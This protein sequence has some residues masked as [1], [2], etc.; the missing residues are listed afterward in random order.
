MTSSE[1]LSAAFSTWR[2]VRFAALGN[3]EAG[4][5]GRLSAPA[6]AAVEPSPSEVPPQP[7]RSAPV[8]SRQKS[9]ETVRGARIGGMLWR[10]RVAG[11][12]DEKEIEMAERAALVTGASSGIGLA[13]ARN[14]GEEGSALPSSAP[15]PEKLEEAAEGLRGEASRSSRFRPTW[16]RRTTSSPSSP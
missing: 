7:A 12:V 10:D 8:A 6:A 11:V 16:P 4:G 15:R 1:G 14:L 2:R 13:I 9:A 5:A 3:S